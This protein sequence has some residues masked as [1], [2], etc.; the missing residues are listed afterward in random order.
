MTRF[1]RTVS[2]VSSVSCWGTTPIRRADLRAVAARIQAEDDE[3]AVA[4]R[5][6][7]A[8]HPHR[9]GLAGAVRAEEAERLARR[10]VEVDRVDGGELAEPLRQAAGMDQGRVGVAI[11]GSPAGLAGHVQW[12]AN[13][14]PGNLDGLDRHDGRDGGGVGRGRIRHGSVMVPEAVA[15]SCQDDPPTSWRRSLKRAIVE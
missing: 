6:D 1:S 2:S 14:V 11:R 5:R 10:D 9:R 8:D 3:L 12:V 13:L 4:D 7:A 15:R